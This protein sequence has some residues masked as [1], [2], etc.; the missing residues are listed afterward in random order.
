MVPSVYSTQLHMEHL[1]E[2]HSMGNYIKL[3]SH[4]CYKI[5]KCTGLCS[6][7][8]H[9]SLCNPVKSWQRYIAVTDICLFIKFVTLFHSVSLMPYTRMFTNDTLALIW[10]YQISKVDIKFFFSKIN[11]T[12]WQKK[13]R[14]VVNFQA[15]A[16]NSYWDIFD[17]NLFKN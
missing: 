3:D 11:P 8:W 14:S 16:L 10:I 2:K 15:T 1:I 9:I 5:F 7:K 12:V 17:K 13:I 4:R 6:T